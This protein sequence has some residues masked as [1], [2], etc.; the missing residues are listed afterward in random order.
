MYYPTQTK[1]IRN[2]T[3]IRGRTYKQTQRYIMRDDNKSK[4]RISTINIPNLVNTPSPVLPKTQGSQEAIISKID[5]KSLSKKTVDEFLKDFRAGRLN[6]IKDKVEEDKK[7][8]VKKMN[9]NIEVIE[10][11]EEE[12]ILEKIEEEEEE[13]VNGR[14]TPQLILE[15]NTQEENED[16]SPISIQV[17]GEDAAIWGGLLQWTLYTDD[18]EELQ[19]KLKISDFISKVGERLGNNPNYIQMLIKKNKKGIGRGIMIDC[20]GLETPKYSKLIN[21]YVKPEE[22][23]KGYCKE[24]FNA[25]FKR[26]T[27]ENLWPVTLDV[28]DFNTK[29]LNLYRNLG[30]KIKSRLWQLYLMNYY[31]SDLEAFEEQKKIVF[32]NYSDRILRKNP[33][34]FQNYNYLLVKAEEVQEMSDS[35]N[36]YNHQNFKN[37][38]REDETISGNTLKKLFKNSISEGM[39]DSGG[40]YCITHKSCQLI[41]GFVYITKYPHRLKG[42][43]ICHL[44]HLLVDHRFKISHETIAR[45]IMEQLLLHVI[46]DLKCVEIYVECQEVQETQWFVDVIV[47]QF[48]F[49]NDTGLVMVKEKEEIGNE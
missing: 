32:K 9:I 26:A 1:I 29:A 30:F 27:E 16:N 23:R 33:Y 7:L 22:R 48:C 31:D 20:Q 11:E 6:K 2:I 4:V 49:R 3:P 47:K 14:G 44:T 24:M 43:R 18:C 25:I 42:V 41:L 13:E 45:D 21:V 38:L 12:E 34:K 40:L 15:E 36:F 19:K 37:L 46:G 17:N 10:E 39:N 28:D 5:L 8:E 35:P